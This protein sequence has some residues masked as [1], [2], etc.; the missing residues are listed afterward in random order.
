MRGRTPK[1]AEKYI[2]QAAHHQRIVQR[3]FERFLLRFLTTF[4][5]IHLFNLESLHFIVNLEQD[6]YLA[7]TRAAAPDA[8]VIDIGARVVEIL[9]CKTFE[10]F[11]FIVPH[12]GTHGTGTSPR[13]T[14]CIVHER[15]VTQRVVV[16]QILRLEGK[17]DR[18]V[19]ARKWGVTRTGATGAWYSSRGG[20]GTTGIW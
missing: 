7:T 14:C 5:N 13:G 16:I 15:H 18:Y 2:F 19:D 4:Y 9:T 3:A 12:S 11:I 20:P 8:K 10:V 1:Q 17:S 6:Q